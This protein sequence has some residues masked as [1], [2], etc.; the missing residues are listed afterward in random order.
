MEKHIGVIFAGGV[1]KRMH[2]KDKPKQ[3]LNIH[4]KPVI[5]HTLEHFQNND[6]ID[7]I[8]ISCVPEWTN[9]LEKLVDKYQIDKVLKVV[10]G[11]ATGQLSIYNGICAAKEIAGDDPA[12]VLIHDGVRPLISSELLS[13]NIADVREFGSSITSALVKETVVLIDNDRNVISVPTRSQSRIA[14]APQCFWLNDILSAH[15][16]ALR[17]GITDYI[18]SCTLMSNAGFKLHLTEGP[19]DNIK[20]TTPDDFY[21]MRAIL[22]AKEN[23]QIYE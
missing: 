20:I 1:G 16:N 10:N 2:S 3:F 12:I 13:R 5:I 22:D 11:G 7:S 15:N 4:G 19:Y 8:V 14:K 9:Y 18:D 23:L 17:N 6:E 21:M